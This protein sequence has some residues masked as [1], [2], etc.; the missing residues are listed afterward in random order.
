MSALHLGEC[1]AGV[2]YVDRLT[3]LPRS[4]RPTFAVL[5]SAGH[6]LLIERP[7]RF[8][9]MQHDWLDRVEVQP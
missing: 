8:E 5:D 2:P 1:G 7:G 9:A 3:M 6:D 4:P